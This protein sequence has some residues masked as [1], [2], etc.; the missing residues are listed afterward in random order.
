VGSAVRFEAKRTVA[1]T[2][3]RR[4]LL[5]PAGLWRRFSE[6]KRKARPI[7]RTLRL[8]LPLGYGP[9][10][11]GAARVVA[12]PRTRNAGLLVWPSWL[13]DPEQKPPSLMHEI[14]GTQAFPG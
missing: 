12:Q 11:P 2:I 4:P 8:I 1:P 13:H 7:D 3:A 5:V 9:S 14:T 10:M 6:Q